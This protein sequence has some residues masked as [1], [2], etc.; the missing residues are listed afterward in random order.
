MG[1]GCTEFRERV[2]AELH[3]THIGVSRT[4]SLAKG[5][6]WWN[7]MNKKIEEMI[8]NCAECQ[9]VRPVPVKAKPHFWEP[10]TE[11]FQRVHVDFVGPYLDCYFFIVVDAYT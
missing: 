10:A 6:C 4:K 11:P 5:Y 2:L 3:S 7:G 8:A 1:F 9:S